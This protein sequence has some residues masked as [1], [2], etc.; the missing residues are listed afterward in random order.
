M[1]RGDPGGVR[2]TVGSC[3]ERI[4]KMEASLELNLLKGYK[5]WLCKYIN[6]RGS[7]DEWDRGTGDG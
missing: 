3:R 5:K 2:I 7:A 4:R 6:E 1:C